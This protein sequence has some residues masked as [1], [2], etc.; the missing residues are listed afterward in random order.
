MGMRPRAATNVVRPVLWQDEFLKMECFLVLAPNLCFDTPP[1]PAPNPSSA[2]CGC[3][4]SMGLL[5]VDALRLTRPNLTQWRIRPT[6][7]AMYPRSRLPI[8][9]FSFCAQF[10]MCPTPHPVSIFVGLLSVDP[11][12]L[13]R[14]P[15]LQRKLLDRCCVST[16][17]S[18]SKTPAFGEGWKKRVPAYALPE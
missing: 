10:S 5:S 15:T 9:A 11:L 16:S 12:L 6:E 14:V 4:I 1:P 13:T 3:S 17:S 7:R 2:L 8:D 18:S